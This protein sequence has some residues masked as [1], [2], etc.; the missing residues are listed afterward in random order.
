MAV[1]DKGSLWHEQSPEEQTHRVALI[2]EGWLHANE[3]VAEFAAKDEQVLAIRVEVP[4]CFAPVL[5]KVSTVAIVQNKSAV[6]T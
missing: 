3:D 2:A 4:R 6:Y 5:F 1:C